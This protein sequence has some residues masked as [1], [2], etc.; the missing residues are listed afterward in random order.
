M[1]IELAL[2]SAVL[3]ILLTAALFYEIWDDRREDEMLL[4]RARRNLD[5]ELDDLTK[6]T[7]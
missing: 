5:G 3:A 1:P 6:P 4:D 7:V 2:G